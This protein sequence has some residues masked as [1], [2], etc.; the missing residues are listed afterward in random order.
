MT[1]TEEPK[2]EEEVKEAYN[3]Q[4]FRY[5]DDNK[6]AGGGIVDSY[7]EL[8]SACNA[9]GKADV[10]QIAVNALAVGLDTLG[11]ILDPLGTLMAAGDGWLIEPI[12]LLREPLDLLMGDPDEIQANATLLQ[13]EVKKIEGYAAEHDAA[14]AKITG[15]QGDAA[16]KF[17][18]S[19]GDLTE[20]IKSFGT[21]VNG[22]SEETVRC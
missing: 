21:V 18:K 1:Q 7:N 9:E 8:V 2:T 4:G 19:M 5:D 12:G 17:R 13:M 16:D 11:L 3:F 10:A 22:A 20:E 15:W 14:L 6:F